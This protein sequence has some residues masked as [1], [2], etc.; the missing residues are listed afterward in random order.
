[1][2]MW[3]EWKRREMPGDLLEMQRESFLGIPIRQRQEINGSKGNVMQE[4]G[5]DVSGSG[6]GSFMGC[7]N[8]VLNEMI[9]YH[10]AKFLN[11]SGICTS[12][13][14]C[15][16]KM[17]FMTNNNHFTCCSTGVLSSRRL[18]GQRNAIPTRLSEYA[19]PSLEWS[20]Y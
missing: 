14:K 6:L 4:S 16:N 3:R 18:S 7:C 1:M 8:S 12:N 19:A 9:P 13:K 5:K 17:R 11:N 10:A 20:K 15:S 2:A